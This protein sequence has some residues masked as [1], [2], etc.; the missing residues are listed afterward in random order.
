MYDIKQEASDEALLNRLVYV[1][2]K[3]TPRH[4]L[5]PNFKGVFTL[6]EL[7]C[8]IGIYSFMAWFADGKDEWFWVDDYGTQ[9]TLIL[10]LIDCKS[11]KPI[12]AEGVIR[13]ANRY[14][15]LNLWRYRDGVKPRSGSKKET[16]WVRRYR[17]PKRVA[18]LAQAAG[19]RDR[20][21]FEPGIRKGYLQSLKYA[22]EVVRFSPKD[23][24]WKR[25]RDQQY[26]TKKGQ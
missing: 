10:E 7:L 18:I 8:N 21:E 14:F 19:E 13:A 23:R 24:S 15:E 16:K 2:D 12:C 26:K 22:Y 4:G 9:R 17:R 3:Q 1:S 20:D 5:D 6:Y 11:Q 25:F